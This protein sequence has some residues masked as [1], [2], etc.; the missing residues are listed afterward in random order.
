MRKFTADEVL[1]VLRERIK[2]ASVRKV[3]EEIGVSSPY[4]YDILHGN[5]AISDTVAIA[6]G[7]E[8]EI[9]TE[10]SFRKIA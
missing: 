7:Y 8:R 10:V 5:R 2:Q 3:A 1:E 4:L 6:L 9:V